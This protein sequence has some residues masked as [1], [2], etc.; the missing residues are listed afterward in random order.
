MLGYGEAELLDGFRRDW[1]LFVFAGSAFYQ[2]AQR[3][4]EEKGIP[5]HGEKRDPDRGIP[6]CFGGAYVLASDSRPDL[7][8]WMGGESGYMS[9]GLC[10]YRHKRGIS[11]C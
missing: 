11:G 3:K 9:A 1:D 5:C 6:E 10:L 4:K 8:G 7:V 2:E